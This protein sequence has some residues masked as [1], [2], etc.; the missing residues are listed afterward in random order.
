MDQPLVASR[1]EVIR[2]SLRRDPI[3]WITALILAAIYLALAGRYDTFRNELYFIACGRRPAFGYAD[4]PPLV[5]LIAAATQLF[6]DSTWL[7]RIPSIAAA[8]ALIPLTAAFALLLGGNRTAA[9][10][11]GLAAAIAPMLIGVASTLGTSS[12]EP[13]L[14][15]LCAYLIARA[16]IQEDRNAAL[17]AGIVAGISL[18][19]K[20]GIS[21][22]M[23]GLAIG[24]ILT[25]ARRVITSRQLWYGAIVG[26]L[27]AAPSFIWQTAHDWPFLQSIHYATEYRNYTG[28]PLRFEIKQ[29]FAMNFVLAPLWIA[30]IIAPFVNARL[31]EARFLAIAFIAT[32][33]VIIASHGKDYYL[34]PAY[35]T[36]F[37]AGAVAC[38]GLNRWIPRVW[39][40]TAIAFSILGAPIVLPILDPPALAHFLDTTHLRP[41]PNE[42]EA[43]G[44]PLTQVFSD[45]LGWRDMEKQVATVYR[46]LP[47]EERSRAAI[48]AMDYGE[49][50]ALDVYGRADGLPPPICGQLQYYFWGTRG[51]DGSVIIQVN[52][53]PARLERAC[54]KS[55]VAGHFGG[56]YVL[57][58]ENGPIIVC[59]GLR[60]PLDQIWYR[61][62]RMH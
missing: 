25:S 28:T 36:M 39:F 43:V 30:G 41:S 44:A 21:T 61:F 60:R 22:W 38:A 15:T 49:A 14:W 45:E 59:H 55:E 9:W 52:G 54:E 47:P 6:G 23:I 26:I 33:A 29:I 3:V 7:L 11:A 57:P 10:M 4:M 31:R 13:L 62:R 48:L 19:T 27:I 17:W 35:P 51:H 2:A 40:A 37:A 34:A 20:Y 1:I 8:V 53:D 50:A 42:R 32:T 16:A 5:P 46:S 12:F 18:E 58:F 24:V 56:P